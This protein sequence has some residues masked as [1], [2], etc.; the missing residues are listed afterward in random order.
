MLSDK[1]L[2]VGAIPIETGLFI[3]NSFVK[4][5]GEPFVTVN[6]ATEVRHH[7]LFT[8]TFLSLT[9]NPPCS[10]GDQELATFLSFTYNRE[11]YP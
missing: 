8:A 3:N 2:A 7:L 6:P 11:F 9:Y 10:Q 1:G 4:G 5:H